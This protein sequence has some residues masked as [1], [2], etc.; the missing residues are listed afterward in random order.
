MDLTA[1]RGPDCCI[2]AKLEITVVLEMTSTNFAV[3]R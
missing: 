2:D 3:R 1:G